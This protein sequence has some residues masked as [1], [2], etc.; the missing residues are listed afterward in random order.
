MVS[1]QTPQPALESADVGSNVE[2]FYASGLGRVVAVGLFGWFSVIVFIATAE[3]DRI[4]AS[5]GW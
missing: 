4:R 5:R 1:G 3:A 2:N